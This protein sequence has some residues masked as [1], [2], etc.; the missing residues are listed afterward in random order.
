M[1]ELAAATATAAPAAAPAAAAPAAAPAAPAAPTA[2]NPPPLDGGSGGNGV[3]D[4]LKRLNWLEVGFGVL[5]SAAL[6]YTIYYYKYNINITKT[7][8]T[9][10]QN[11]LDD[12]TIKLSDVQSV[13]EKNN[14]QQLT[15]S[16]T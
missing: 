15:Q 7:F 4:I 8:Q 1:D 9:D 2:Y 14:Q 6:F 11:K 10:F 16:F 12:L 5:G 13:V 3:M